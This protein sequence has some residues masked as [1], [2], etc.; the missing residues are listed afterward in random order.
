MRN[1]QSFRELKAS[2]RQSLEGNYRQAISVLI[3]IQ[4]LSLLPVYLISFFFPENTVFQIICAELVSFILSAFV[5]L[6]DLGNS[7]F[8]LKLACQQPASTTDI[9]YGFRNN[10]NAALGISLI[11]TFVS[12]VC[13]IPFSL[14]NYSAAFPADPA[15][16]TSLLL[17]LS[18]LLLAGFFTS[19][20][21]LLPFE[22]A[23]Y[24]L[25]DFPEYTTTQALRFSMKLMKG[26]YFRFLLFLLSFV[27]L[28]L[29]CFFTCGLGLLWVLPYFHASCTAFYLDLIKNYEK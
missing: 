25:L 21:L 11:F 28:I 12:S 6:L 27:P 18:L 5:K 19:T 7:L 4:I 1:Y 23:F 9:F 29:L 22:Q 15:G 16:A 26:N 14:F 20:L 3:S 13:L 8:Y 2:A 10:R 17:Q 24:A